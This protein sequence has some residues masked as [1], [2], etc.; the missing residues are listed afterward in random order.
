M[1]LIIKNKI[2]IMDEMKFNIRSFDPSDLKK[3]SEIWFVA[4]SEV[5]SFLG[6]QRLLEQKKLIEDIYLLNSETYVACYDG[7]PIGF[8]GLMDTF[9]GGLFIDPKMQGFGIGRALVNYALKLKEGL[10][11]EVYFDNQKAYLFYRHLGFEE[12]SRKA[13]DDDG[14]PFEVVHM[15]LK[16]KE[17]EL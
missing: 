9:I 5:H 15:K 14:L 16:Y 3:L 13:K 11:L 12:I 1:S 4:S 10:Q 7:I 2:L 8:I 6:K 17:I